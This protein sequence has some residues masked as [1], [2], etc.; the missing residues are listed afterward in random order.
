MAIRKTQINFAPSIELLGLDATI[1][2]TLSRMISGCPD[3]S[4]AEIAEALSTETGTHVSV[5]MLDQFTAE[6]RSR[7]RFPAAW[8][9]PFCR[10]TGNDALQRVLL[11]PEL[12]QVLRIG[13]AELEAHRLKRELSGDI[14]ECVMKDDKT[15][16]TN[17]APRTLRKFPDAG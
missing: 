7:Y 9:I 14:T 10:I 8:V 17:S 16:K 6:S 11:G 5:R 2:K 13:E 4:R 3:K 1:R 15:E 12:G